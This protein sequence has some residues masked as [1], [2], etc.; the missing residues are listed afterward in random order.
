MSGTGQANTSA[1]SRLTPIA[2][3]LPIGTDKNGDAVHATF[4]FFQTIQRILSYLGQPSPS[5]PSG[6]SSATLSEQV[7][8]IGAGVVSGFE[9]SP[10]AAGL[11][12]RVTVLEDASGSLTL[13]PAMLGLNARI[14]ALENERA[15]RWLP[16]APS[17]EAVPVPIYGPLSN[18]DLP[19]SLMTGTPDDAIKGPTLI[20]DAVGQVILVQVA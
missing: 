11:S 13:P 15:P 18:G 10:E 6:G 17:P 4:A 19:G 1:P 8:A 16:S 7:T 12:G 20:S 3:D 2:G 9:L 5:S 14:A